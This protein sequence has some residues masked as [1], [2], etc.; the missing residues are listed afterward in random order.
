MLRSVHSLVLPALQARV[1]L[2]VNHVLLQEPAATERLRRH[3]GRR[4]RIQASP[5]ARW[6]PTLPPVDLRLTPAGLFE[7]EDAGQTL[8]A[9]LHLRIDVPQ[10][11]GQLMAVAAGTMAPPVRI[12][13]DAGLAADMQW[14][15]DNLRWDL[16]SDLSS[17][18]GP[19]PAHQ[20]MR[21]GRAVAAAL[22]NLSPAAPSSGV[23]RG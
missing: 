21:V 12:E 15:V 20:L 16:E 23:D 5:P 22:R 8:T 11:L 10:D 17:A 13:G 6:M 4:L 14:L 7:I 1:V 18:F 3:D 19:A 9:D 2:L